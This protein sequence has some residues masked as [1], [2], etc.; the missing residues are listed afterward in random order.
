[1]RAGTLLSLAL[2]VSFVISAAVDSPVLEENLKTGTRALPGH[3]VSGNIVTDTIWQKDG[4]PWIVQNNISVVKD[5]VLTIEPGVTVLFG[6][7]VRFTIDGKLTAVGGPLSNQTIVF[8]PIS[9]NPATGDWRGIRF[10]KDS[11]GSMLR[12]C[13]ISHAIGAVNCTERSS[14]TIQNCMIFSSFTYGINCEANST[15]IIRNNFINVSTFDGILCQNYSNP[16]IENNDISYCL[17]GILVYSDPRI[18][19]NTFTSCAWGIMCWA[20]SA[21]IYDNTLIHCIDGIFSFFADPKI[22]NNTI[23]SSEGNGTRFL[24]SPDAQFYNNTMQ[25][26]DAGVDIPYDTRAI[27]ATMSG[28]TVNGQDVNDFYRVDLNDEVIEN[29]YIDS[30]EALGFYGLPTAQGSLTLYD[31]Q[32]VTFRDCVIKNSMN[33]IYA[34]N[35][36][37]EIYNSTLSKVRKADVFLKEMSYARSYNHSVNTSKVYIDDV[38]NYLV[39]YGELKIEVEN[40]TGSPVSDAIVEVRELTSVLH[41]TT[42]GLT[43]QTSGLLVREERVSDSGVINYTL[44]VEVWS[45]G[46]TFADNPRDIDVAQVQYLKFSDLGDIIAPYVIASNIE[47]GAQGIDVNSTII[48]T[49]SEPMNQTATQAAFSISGNITGT[50]TW[51]GSNLTFTPDPSLAY[52]GYYTVQVTTGAL[53][54]QGNQLDTMFAFSFTAEPQPSSADYSVVIVSAVAVFVILGLASYFMLKKR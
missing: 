25:F 45:A 27:L 52:L 5:V 30:G 36:S 16:V 28:N 8:K 12:Y 10:L 24:G 48:I 11:T 4:L 23:I 40:F 20:S 50:F 42:T 7:G 39:S 2:V 41:N 15:P 9:S 18:E 38:G 21:H 44:T 19:G 47:N 29:L 3:F 35:S 53:D 22:E 14:P 51:D 37:F 46:M 1:M 43:G 31:C 34:H 6:T 54:V 26:N 49:F 33:C 13:E 17:Y 32:N